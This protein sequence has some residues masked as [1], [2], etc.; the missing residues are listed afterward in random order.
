MQD[1]D[2]RAMAGTSRQGTGWPSHAAFILRI[3]RLENCCRLIA[4]VPNY[5]SHLSLMILRFGVVR[6][7][8]DD[9]G[10]VVL[11]EHLHAPLA[12]T[13]LIMST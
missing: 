6:S 8:R 9:C 13:A 7:Y 2:G 12:A 4:G 10:V 11:S 3:K 1:L 5:I